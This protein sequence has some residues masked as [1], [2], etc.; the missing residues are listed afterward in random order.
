MET[1]AAASHLLR[2]LVLTV[3][4]PCCLFAQEHS[5]SSADGIPQHIGVPCTAGGQE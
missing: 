4:P 5:E 1:R 3:V 2:S